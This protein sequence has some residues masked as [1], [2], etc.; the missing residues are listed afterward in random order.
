VYE[1]LSPYQRQQLLMRMCVID[2]SE[3][4]ELPVLSQDEVAYTVELSENIVKNEDGSYTMNDCDEK[5]YL[6]IPE[7]SDSEVYV[8]FENLNLVQDENDLRTDYGIYAKIQKDGEDISG[9]KDTL[10]ASTNRNHMSAGKDDWILNLG[11]VSESADTLV[12]DFFGSGT[13]RFDALKVYV[14][15]KS[16]IQT[17]FSCLNRVT[18][19][20][21]LKTNEISANINVTDSQYIFI[22]V[23]YS[24][25]W[26]AE[27]NGEGV[28]IEKANGA[29]MAI[30]VEEGE[31]DLKLTFTTPYLK[32]GLV[33]SVLAVLI[34]FILEPFNV[35]IKGI[36]NE[37]G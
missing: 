34:I 36:L 7:V 10:S 23:P 32:T 30:K 14:K 12:L 18:D 21:Q 4:Y 37:N 20:V 17:S 28:S 6:K 35:L 8:Y 11:Y 3:N 31:Y 15:P 25:G 24:K 1:G 9:N 29:F 16:E 26:K 5:I 2:A 13:Y 22:S 27:L 33:L 19:D